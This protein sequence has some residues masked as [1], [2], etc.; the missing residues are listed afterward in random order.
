[1]EKELKS[2]EVYPLPVDA[3]GRLLIP[4]RLRQA[5]GLQPGYVVV[6]WVENGRLVLK[7]RRTLE[8]EL[9]SMFEDVEENLADTLIAERREE[10]AREG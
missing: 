7:P 2:P 5:M 8:Q 10:A 9:W 6:A 4:K 1:M 3:Q